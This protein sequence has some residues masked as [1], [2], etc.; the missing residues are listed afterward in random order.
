VFSMTFAASA[1]QSLG[2][3]AGD[4][5]DDGFEPVLLVAGVD[6]LRRVAELEIDP[7]PEARGRGETGPAEFAGQAGI[8]GGFENNDRARPQMGSDQGAGSFERRKVGAPFGIDRGRHR[9]DKKAGLVQRVRVIGKP[10]PR[11]AQRRLGDLTG[12]ILGIAQRGDPLL[13]N[14]KTDD[15]LEL[16]RQGEGDG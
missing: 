9:D 6:A 16:F 10:K 11:P 3:F 7:L 5:L 12:L 13:R 8:D 15:P 2:V 14:V 4:D 1:L